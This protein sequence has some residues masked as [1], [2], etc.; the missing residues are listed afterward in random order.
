MQHRQNSEVSFLTGSPAG[1]RNAGAEFSAWR[2]HTS[3]GNRR[4]TTATFSEKPAAHAK[5][6]EGGRRLVRQG[7]HLL[8]QLLFISQEYC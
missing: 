2:R 3:Y 1:R 7:E 8:A 6:T 5:K 4:T